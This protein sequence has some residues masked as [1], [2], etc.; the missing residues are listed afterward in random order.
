M[1]PCIWTSEWPRSLQKPSATRPL[2]DSKLQS[3]R[4][5]ARRSGLLCA[6]L[7]SAQYNY[8]RQAWLVSTRH[9]GVFYSYWTHSHQCCVQALP[10]LRFLYC[11]EAALGLLL[12]SAY[13]PA[14]F[15][16]SSPASQTFDKSL[17]L[18]PSKKALPRQLL[19]ALQ[20]GTLAIA[21]LCLWCLLSRGLKLQWPY[22]NSLKGTTA[23][24]IPASFSWSMKFDKSG[25]AS[26]KVSATSKSCSIANSLF[27]CTSALRRSVLRNLWA[28]ACCQNRRQITSNIKWKCCPWH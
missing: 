11:E 6:L 12:L 22:S 27:P 2:L 23:R 5:S 25:T 26:S 3:D 18:R 1:C 7:Y 19:Q 16:S 4:I 17:K 9:F 24:E 15:F 20:R 28:S 8:A 10:V 21:S 14:P 13:R